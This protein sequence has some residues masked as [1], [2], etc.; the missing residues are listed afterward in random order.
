MQVARGEG[1]PVT[2]R[3]PPGFATD[4]YIHSKLH[5]TMFTFRF[6][7]IDPNQ[8]LL[9]MGDTEGGVCVMEFSRAMTYLFIPAVGSN[10]LVTFH[11]LLKKKYDGV[12]TTYFPKVNHNFV[13]SIIVVLYTTRGG[14][15]LSC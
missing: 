15:S 14:S 10:N 7:P 2:P 3:T 12:K 5:K 8:A 6:N 11:Q 13:S 1:G 9:V 4:C